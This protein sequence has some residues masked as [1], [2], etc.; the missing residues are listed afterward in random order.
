MR[1]ATVRSAGRWPA[2]RWRK[3]RTAGRPGERGRSHRRAGLGGIAGR[4]GGAV[5]DLLEGE[6]TARRPPVSD[7]FKPLEPAASRARPEA[8]DVLPIDLARGPA[9]RRG[10]VP[11]AVFTTWAALSVAPLPEARQVVL[12]SR[13]GALAAPAAPEIERRLGRPL[14]LRSGG[15]QAWQQGGLALEAG[16]DAARALSESGDV[17]KRP[18]RGR[19][20]TV[21]RCGPASIGSSGWSR[22]SDATARMDLPC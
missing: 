4:A 7:G 6:E 14:L 19:M 20:M 22:S 12:T 1:C 9:H 21:P 3:G 16:L 13:D 10:H 17:D 8:G 5:L 11:G 2:F 18:T 15:T